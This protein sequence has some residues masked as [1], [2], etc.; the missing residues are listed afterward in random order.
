MIL[1]LNSRQHAK[2]K[3]DKER[4]SGVAPPQWGL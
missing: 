1:N 3:E 2:T 4:V